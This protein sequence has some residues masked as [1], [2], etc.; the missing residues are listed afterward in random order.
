MTTTAEKVAKI[1]LET[2]DAYSKARYADWA[3]CARA[4]VEDC[5]YSV[6]QA[7]KVL[8]SKWTRWAADFADITHEENEKYYGVVKTQAIVDFCKSEQAKGRFLPY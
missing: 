8:N 7:I 5:G 1:L 2:E 4:M 6:P 3:D